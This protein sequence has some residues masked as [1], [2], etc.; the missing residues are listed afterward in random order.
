MTIFAFILCQYVVYIHWER[1]ARPTGRFYARVGCFYGA[2]L[3]FW[4][5]VEPIQKWWD[6]L[7]NV[8]PLGETLQSKSNHF[9]IG[10]TLIQKPK[11][12]PI[13]TANEQHK[14]S[15]VGQADF[16]SGITTLRHHMKAKLNFLEWPKGF[17]VIENW[18]FPFHKIDN[19][20]PKSTY[21]FIDNFGLKCNIFSNEF[22]INCNFHCLF[23]P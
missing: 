11:V 9:W 20:N 7:C 23:S 19:Q 16:R 5:N 12:K 17:C 15:P 14:R 13:K 4:I 2:T 10:K 6:L 1:R 21:H 18:C 8:E 3:G 22:T